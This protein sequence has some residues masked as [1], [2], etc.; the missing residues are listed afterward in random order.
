MPVHEKEE[1]RVNEKEVIRLVTHL[2]PEINGCKAHK[3][4]HVY[5]LDY[6]LYVHGKVVVA[7]AEVKCRTSTRDELMQRGSVLMNLSKWHRAE[8]MCRTLRNGVYYFIVRTADGH[9]GVRKFTLK[10]LIFPRQ[11]VLAG[12]PS[13]WK[14]EPEDREPCVVVYLNEFEWLTL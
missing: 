11:I 4:K 8:Q 5:G 10:D 9:I 3:L 1:D 7:W 14:D 2:V 6:A 13:R 12:T